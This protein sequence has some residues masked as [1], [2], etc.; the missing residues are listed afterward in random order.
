MDQDVKKVT[1]ESSEARVSTLPASLMDNYRDRMGKL[2]E[3]TETQKNRLKKWLKSR[4]DEWVQDTSDLHQ[5]LV[6]DNDLVEGI[7]YETDYPWEGASNVHVPLTETYMEIYK[8]IFKRSILGADIIWY[9]ETDSDDPQV[10][11]MLADVEGMLNYKARNEWNI[12]EC[13]KAVLWITPRDGLAAMEINWEEQYKKASDIILLTNE[14]DFLKEF[15]SPEEAGLSEEEWFGLAQE[16]AQASDEFPVEVPITFE[17]RVY[18]GCKGEAVDLVNFVTIPATVPDI[19]HE[20]CRGY[21]KRYQ[22]RSA[23]IRKKIKEGFYYKD[24]AEALLNKGISY[25]PNDFT[26]AQDEME[27]LRRTSTDGTFLN[28]ALNI[29]VTLNGFDK[30]E[31]TGDE[32]YDE[33]M[34]FS[35][36]YDLQNDKLLRLIEFPYRVHNYATFRIDSRPNRLV[37]K[38]VPAKTRD[39]NDEVDTQHNQRINARSISTVP[40]FKGLSSKKEELQ[41][42]LQQQKMKPGK[43][44]WVNDFNSFD[45][46][47]IQPTD[48]GESMSEEKNSQAILDL[49]LG[50]AASL[51]SGGAP[52]QDP[53]APGNK[54]AMMIA[55][56]NLRMDDPLDELRDGVEQVGD[57]CLSHTYQFGPPILQFM[58]PQE[59]G[60]YETKTIHKKFLRKNI[61][62]KMNGITVTLNPEVE[63]QKGFQLHQMLLT[64]PLYANNPQLRMEGLRYAL[65]A[66]RIQGRNKMLPPM[67][68]IQQQQIQTQKIAMK[69]MEVEKLMQAKAQQEEELKGRLSGA[70]QEMDIKNTARKMAET[71]LAMNGAAN[72]AMNGQP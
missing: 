57:I 43:V 56:S 25:Q 61:R 32:K 6:Y 63:M 53:N 23:S 8:S 37:G 48:L 17:K 44:F 34:E 69:E 10:Q 18:Y 19:R 39:L 47:K 27:G 33:E 16:A 40:M 21:G 7:V 72:G 70:K 51:L 31:E 55:Q 41:L 12:A 59:G 54:T 20:L 2:V 3:L 68:E 38:S 4:L 49:Y 13:L 46:F 71:N 60:G 28:Y 64:E 35:V 9:G 45:Q 42:D 15:P 14:Q 58:A 66:G 5:N 50:S 24:E 67:Q 62:M 11:E 30:N 26:K 65:R 22:Q 52:T 36:E 29:S 1:V